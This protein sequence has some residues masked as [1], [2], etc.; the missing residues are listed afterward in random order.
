MKRT[1]R[2]GS[3]E[4]KL[5]VAQTKLVMEQIQA[6]HPELKLELITM[7]T[8]GDKILD[9]S[10]D[11]IGGKGLFVKE[12]DQA[13]LQGTIDLAIHSMKDMP[14]EESPELPLAA[15]FPRGDP[16][17]VLVVPVSASHAPFWS[18][19]GS[20]SPRRKLQLLSLFP[21]A[22][23]KSIRGNVLTR[24]EKLEQ[25]D[26]TSLVLAAAGLERL[27]L[28]HR[29]SHFFSTQEMI[30]AAGQGILAIQGRKGE[31]LSFLQDI[32]CP[33]TRRVSLAERAFIRALQGGCSSPIAAYGEIHGQ[34]LRLTGLYWNE[35][36]TY[37]TH[38]L[39][40]DASKP[41][42][43]GDALARDIQ[44]EGKECHIPME[45]SGW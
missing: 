40:G 19:V 32:N 37:R 43:V 45:K 12:L 26:F 9:R 27:G 3:R 7:K 11:K 5:A 36:D 39:Y 15:L 4:S 23:I 30:P 18:I 20:S 16:R 29:V 41:E 38:I 14:M 6:H 22:E 1:I 35:G 34:E 25:D 24:L 28:G 2:I 17:D 8:T 21:E 44:K 10:L 42:H 33:K 31:D 13:L